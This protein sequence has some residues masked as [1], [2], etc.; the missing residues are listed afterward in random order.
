MSEPESQQMGVFRVR[1]CGHSS[2]FY[3]WPVWFFGYILGL[4][5]FVSGDQ[6][7]LND[8]ELYGANWHSLL[9]LLYICLILFVLYFKDNKTQGLVH[10]FIITSA[11]ILII[12]GVYFTMSCGVL[13]RNISS[14]L[15]FMNT[16][17]FFTFSTGLL[18]IWLFV[19][20]GIDQQSVWYLQPGLVIHQQKFASTRV[21]TMEGLTVTMTRDDWPCHFIL[22]LGLMGDIRLV[23]GATGQSIIIP[24]VANV[25][26]KMREARVLLLSSLAEHQP[27]TS[28]FEKK[29]P[30]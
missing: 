16:S 29:T 17:F 4:L 10:T 3:W 24:N 11:I 13:P 18:A 2:T 25:S 15:V 12:F 26:R 5:T 22:G 14:F 19:V 23:I 8:I 1:L 30:P 9:N 27:K 6:N 21:T 20:F 28:K 7:L